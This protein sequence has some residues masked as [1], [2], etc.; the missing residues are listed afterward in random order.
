METLAFFLV[1]LLVVAY[2]TVSDR[3]HRT[4]LTPAI[5]FTVLGILGGEVGLGLIDVSIEHEGVRL[6]MELT[7]ILVLF[8]DASRIDVA[9]LRAEFA[10]PL[11]AL[12]VGLP[13]VAIAGTIAGIVILGLPLW[14]A[15]VL[16][17]VLAPTDAALAE[18]ILINAAIPPR[19]RQTVNVESGL[20]DGLALP[21]LTIAI[22][23][24]ALDSDLQ[25][26]GELVVFVLRQIGLGVAVGGAVALIGGRAIGWAHDR[27]WSARSFEALSA[28]GLAVLAFAGA[29][30][31]GGNGFIAAFVA[32]LVMGTSYRSMCTPIFHFAEAQSQLFTLLTFLFFGALVAGPA[33]EVMELEHV[34]YAVVSLTAVRMIP[35]AVALLG[36][37]AKPQTI[38]LI[39][40]FGP[41]GIASILFALVVLEERIDHAEEVFL[42]MAITVLVS[43]LA[44]GLTA[45]PLGRRYAASLHHDEDMMEMD[46]AMELPLRSPI[47]MGPGDSEP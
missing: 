25:S 7:L 1:A 5:V 36:S 31:V 45:I 23:L 38:A 35:M 2:T 15:A 14:T 28:L 40:W 22:G 33:L 4:I 11:R 18:P 9:L 27:E 43:I 47:A 26:G 34:L 29:E 46:N 44:H 39:G 24:A 13:L 30:L 32:G 41:R 3:I 10:W 8:I 21:L 37:G 17:V 6:V 19:V 42:V 20:N 16:A 12:V